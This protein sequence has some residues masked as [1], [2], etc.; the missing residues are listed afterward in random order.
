M[1]ERLQVQTPF[2]SFVVFV[3]AC[4]GKLFAYDVEKA[5]GPCLRERF[6]ADLRLDP[7]RKAR[8]ML[9]NDLAKECGFLSAQPPK[10]HPDE[11]SY[12]ACAVGGSIAQA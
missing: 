6:V 2:G 7:R 1:D 10:G 4:L 11:S 3:E 5:R 8:V 12:R 9:C